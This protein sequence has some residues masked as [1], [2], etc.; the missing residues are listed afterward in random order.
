M[1]VIIDNKVC[2]GCGTCI[3]VCPCNALIL[4]KELSVSDKKCS[5]CGR[6]V[7]ICPINAL[8]ISKDD[9]EKDK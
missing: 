9:A 7:S 6:C 8:K 1:S 2:D 5:E 3:S 4:I